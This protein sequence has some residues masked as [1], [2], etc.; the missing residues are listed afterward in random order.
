[1]AKL[2]PRKTELYPQKSVKKVYFY[3]ICTVTQSP[4][5]I[6]IIVIVFL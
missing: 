1:M 3:E 6:N 2:Q 4:V 5:T